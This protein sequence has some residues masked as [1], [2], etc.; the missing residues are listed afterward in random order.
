[1]WTENFLDKGKMM[2]SAKDDQKA[3]ERR[4]I[5]MIFTQLMEQ[6]N[7]ARGS[8]QVI[9]RKDQI[10]TSSQKVVETWSQ[11]LKEIARKRGSRKSFENGSETG[12]KSSLGIAKMQPRGWEMGIHP[13]VELIVS[14]RSWSCHPSGAHLQ[15]HTGCR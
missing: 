2:S 7:S 4:E 3:T 8:V 1:L 11:E 5:E 6:I 13:L 10:S 15:N 14:S 12:S 9:D